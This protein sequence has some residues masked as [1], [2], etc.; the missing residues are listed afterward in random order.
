MYNSPEHKYPHKNK[1]RDD[2]EKNKYFKC[3]K[4]MKAKI[5]YEVVKNLVYYANIKYTLFK[6]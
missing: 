1:R 4:E 2:E 3:K 5:L 6:L